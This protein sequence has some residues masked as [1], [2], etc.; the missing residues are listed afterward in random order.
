MAQKNNKARVILKDRKDPINGSM[1]L[2]EIS[3]MENA[4]QYFQDNSMGK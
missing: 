3:K 4:S 1:D 2:D